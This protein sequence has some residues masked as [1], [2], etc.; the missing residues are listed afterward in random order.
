MGIQTIGNGGA[1]LE[2][3]TTFK[4]GRATIRP[5]ECLNWYSCGLQSGLLAGA[6]ANSAVF[7][8]RNIGANPIGVRRVGVG[9][10]VTTGFTAAQKIDYALTVARAFSASDTGG[11][12]TTLTG[13]NAK[14]RSSLATVTAVD[15]RIASTGALG[16]GTKTLDT[17]PLSLV[18]AWTLA[19][20]VGLVIAPNSSNLLQHDTGDYPLV[21]ATNEGFNIMNLTAMGAAGVG[22]LYV[23]FEFA[24]V[25]S[26]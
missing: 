21:L 14:M 10:I 15:C 20:G 3:D 7:S 1:I 11:S 8:F 19:A 13:N 16:A 22:N 17:V 4:A 2:V 9:L 25:P 6:A 23:N 5:M 18:A 24:E 26:Y 12:A